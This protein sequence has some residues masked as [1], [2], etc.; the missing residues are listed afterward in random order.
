MVFIA[1]TALLFFLLLLLSLVLLLLAFVIF[2]LL[3]F[4]LLFVVCLTC[5]VSSLRCRSL[6]K[7][8]ISINHCSK[9]AHL[10]RSVA[11]KYSSSPI[12]LDFNAGGRSILKVLTMLQELWK[13]FRQHAESC[14]DGSLIESL[15]PFYMCQKFFLGPL[16]QVGLLGK[17]GWGVVGRTRCVLNVEVVD[18]QIGCGT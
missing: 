3:Y 7:E 18:G 17:E 11:D 13:P 15:G 6:W 16:W 9:F 8:A 4:I 5:I 10:K 12:L 14:A 2:V 1:F